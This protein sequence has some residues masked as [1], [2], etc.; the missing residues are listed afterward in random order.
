MLNISQEKYDN[1]VKE[2]T[3]A[4][5]LNPVYIK[6]LVKRGEAHEKLE[7]FEETIA[8]MKNILEINPSKM[9]KLGRQLDE[10]SRLLQKSGK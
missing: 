3:K 5:D 10:L 6:A 2:C 8:D 4:L 7:H 9:I 1:T